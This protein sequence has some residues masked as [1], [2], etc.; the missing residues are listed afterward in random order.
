MQ[1]DVDAYDFVEIKDD[2]LARGFLEALAG[3]VDLVS[4]HRHFEEDVFAVGAW[5][6]FACSV[7]GFVDQRNFGGCDRPAARI[8]HRAA[9]AAAGALRAPKWRR[10]AHCY[11]QNHRE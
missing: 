5:L 3:G 2:A 7:R 1:R 11:R 4:P 10:E 8:H 6:N 9:D